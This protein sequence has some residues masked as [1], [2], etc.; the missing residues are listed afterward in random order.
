MSGNQVRYLLLLLSLAPAWG[1]SINLISN[2]TLSCTVTTLPTNAVVAN[3]CNS[4][5]GI[6]VFGNGSLFIKAAWGQDVFTIDY[7]AGDGLLVLNGAADPNLV[8]TGTVLGHL[9]YDQNFII[10]GGS[11]FGFISSSL[12]NNFDSGGGATCG[13]M[14]STGET[15]PNGPNGTVPFTFGVPFS[16]HIVADVNLQLSAI[17]AVNRQNGGGCNNN[18]G[19]FLFDSQGHALTSFDAEPT[20]LPLLE[21]PEPGTW[22]LVSAGLFGCR[23]RKPKPNV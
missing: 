9:E 1:G 5:P 16:V 12:P 8:A 7:N 14:I 11:G 19:I 23:L 10:T 18:N 2:A 17:H 22:L 15:S 20:D 13:V 4:T 6:S 21:T 3:D